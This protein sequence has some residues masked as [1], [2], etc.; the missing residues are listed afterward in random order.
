MTLTAV[1]VSG[2][3]GVALVLLGSGTAVKL[4]RVAALP[5]QFGTVED[6]PRITGSD[7][8]SAATSAFLPDSLMVSILR[9]ERQDMLN[10]FLSRLRR[11][12]SD[13]GLGIPTVMAGMV[14]ARLVLHP[15]S[16]ADFTRV[17]DGR[18]LRRLGCRHSTSFSGWEGSATALD[19]VEYFGA[20]PR[21]L[22]LSKCGGGVLGINV[23]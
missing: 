13:M 23:N 1:A 17:E 18:L 9:T 7:V 20:M 8:E 16:M 14:L 12:R 3:D 11:S 5:V 19:R 2:S 6:H 21:A 22:T 10:P 4:H 15:V